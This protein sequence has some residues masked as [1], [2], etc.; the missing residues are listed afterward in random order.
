MLREAGKQDRQQLLNFLDQHAA[1][2]P[3]VTLRYAVEH[4]E[5]EQR[6]HYM[7]MKKRTTK[8]QK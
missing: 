6:S 5:P 1:T 8:E 4:L 3:R 7:D 2:I